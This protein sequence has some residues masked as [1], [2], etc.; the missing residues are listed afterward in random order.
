MTALWS[1][2]TVLFVV[3]AWSSAAIALPWS[4]RV[5]DS[6]GLPVIDCG[7]AKVVTSSFAF[8]G[9][10]WA[11]A[12]QVTS[13]KVSGPFSYSVTGKNTALKLGLTAKASKTA[14]R[15]LAWEFEWNAD[16]TTADI[17]GGGLVF[18]L[19]VDNFAAKLG[20]P[21]LLP[22]NRGWAWGKGNQRIE[23]AFDPPL[24]AVSFERGQ[25]SE[26]RAFFYRNEIGAGARRYTATLRLGDDFKI[27]P[28]LAERLGPEDTAHWTSGI[29]DWKTAPV[30]LSFLNA[31][32]K[33]AGKRGFL[34]A[35]KDRLE[36]AD[37]TVARFWGTNLTAA[38]LFGTS[39]EN[40]KR[41]A[42]RLSELGFNL[43]RFHHHDSTWVNPNIFGR[44][45]AAATGRLNDEM[46]E[47]LDWWVKCLKDEGV[48]VWLDLHVGRQLTPADNID[49]FSEISK[50]GG[51][52]DLRGYNYV[53]TSIQRAMKRFNADYLNHVNR[54]TGI[55]YSAEPAIAA[56]LVT[57]EN[58]LTN[59]FGNS[60]LADKGVPQHNLLFTSNAELFARAYD[61]PKE[62]ILRTW[63]PG[64]SKIFLNDL[65]KRFH[66]DMAAQLRAL[67]VKVPIVPTSTWGAN[68]ISSLPA[69][70]TGD[71][72]DVHSYGGAGELEKNPL[73]AAG[74]VHWIAA[75][76]VTGKPLSVT[77]WNAEPFPSPDRH[78]LPLYMAASA[79]LQG[80]DALMQYA[81]AQVPLN[82]PGNPSNWHS[83]NDPA[84]IGTLPAAALLFRRQDV[85]E[86]NPGFAFKPGPEQLF[87][88][89]LSAATATGIRTASEKGKV[90]LVLPQTKELPWLDAMQS[91]AGAKAAGNLA[92]SLIEASAES[93][94]SETGELTRDWT[95]GVY[96]I[97]TPRTQAAMGWIGGRAIELAD[98]SIAATTRNATIAVQS[99]EDRPIRESTRIL[100]SLAARSIPKTP[101]AL[102]FLSEPVQGQLVVR[103]P[104][105]LKLFRSASTA[106][107]SELPARYQ[108]GRYLI[109]LGPSLKTSWLVLR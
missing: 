85:K 71:I 107:R 52:A 9:R 8:W 47:K 49:G 38:A 75:A 12:D 2:R 18:K 32:E 36:F 10:N 42:R 96:S 104:R 5:D 57:N 43:V 74:M 29:L 87:N 59:H 26:I 24:A 13:M 73:F 41:E 97:D 22:G 80:W 25:K 70:T 58:D 55:A 79:S 50:Q 20:T 34:A 15:Q 109:D 4:A 31:G 56:L 88:Q 76:Q 103:A 68:P 89:P 28:T 78:T 48:Y 91:P 7:G 46:L 19:D 81:Y 106:S 100:I 51:S 39:N 94:R 61:L 1:L 98:V 3:L 44:P 14:E 95:H 69:L 102:P 23:L 93:A 99:L 105:G 90:V 92:M 65:E 84:L 64:P 53:N 82:G 40:V 86:G 27:A 30:D 6:V 17:I 37:G 35:R 16:A 108:N 33:P 21:E 101:D 63:E 62:K 72:I 67:G 60:L 45:E 83:F 66:V 11:W 54:F 77:E